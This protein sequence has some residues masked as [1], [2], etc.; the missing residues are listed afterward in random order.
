MEGKEEAKIIGMINNGDDT[1]LNNCQFS[2]LDVGLINNGK[3]AKLTHTTFGNDDDKPKKWYEGWWC[4]YIVYP[5][6]VIVIGGVILW[7]LGLTK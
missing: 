6:V 5:L 1:E 3:R 7:R 2:S 4:V